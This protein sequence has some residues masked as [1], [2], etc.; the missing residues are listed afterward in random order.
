[1]LAMIIHTLYYRVFNHRNAFVLKARHILFHRIDQFGDRVFFVDWHDAAAQC[2]I[3]RVQGNGE[4]RI[5]IFFHS[6][7][8]W[9]HS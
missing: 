5:G 8:G 1:M 7:Y 2:I 4:R 6:P 9:H 3:G